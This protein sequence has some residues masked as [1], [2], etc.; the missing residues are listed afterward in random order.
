M[1]CYRFPDRDTF[2][3]LAAAE[4]LVNDDQLITSSHTHA[5]DE[6]GT[7]YEGGT[8]DAEGNVIDP[9]VALDGWHVNVLGIAPEAWDP[10]LCIVNHPVRVFLG[11]A[12]QAPSTDILEEIA[13][14]CTPTSVLH[15]QGRPSAIR[16]SR[17]SSVGTR[18][19][20]PR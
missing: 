1:N 6:V 11:G 3:T 16:R 12:T 4:G 10:F 15:E 14:P 20:K 9:P 17:P 8:F 13:A 19:S 18:R 5:I 2:L 7:I